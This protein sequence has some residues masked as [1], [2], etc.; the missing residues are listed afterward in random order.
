MPPKNAAALAEITQRAQQLRRQ[1][2]S[3]YGRHVYRGWNLAIS[4]A[5]KEYQ[6][7]I[8]SKKS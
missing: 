3:R 4:Q 6:N 1:F 2:P 8:K 7:K 5:A